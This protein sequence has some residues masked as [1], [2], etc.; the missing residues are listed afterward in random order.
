[1]PDLTPFMLNEKQTLL[2]AMDGLYFNPE[3]LVA[4]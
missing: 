4:E 1:V 2:E 3:C